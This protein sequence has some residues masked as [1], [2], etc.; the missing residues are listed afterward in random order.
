MSHPGVA[1]NWVTQPLFDSWTLGIWVAVPL[2]LAVVCYLRGW[3]R[4]HQR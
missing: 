2:G 4:P 1:V 3:L